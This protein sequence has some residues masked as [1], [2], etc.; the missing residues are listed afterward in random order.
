MT[1]TLLSIVASYGVWVVLCSA[2]IS[3]LAVPIPT[4][5][6]MLSAGAF[7]AAGDL[8]IYA[9]FAAS[10]IGAILGDQ[11]GFALGR[12]GGTRI[13]NRLAQSKGRRALLDRAQNFVQRWGGI[14]VF[15]STWLFAPLG[16]WVN[17]V[18]GANRLSWLRFSIADFAGEVIW[19]SVYIGLGFTFAD[20]IT[21]I[22]SLLSSSVAFLMGGGLTILLGWLLV[23]AIKKQRIQT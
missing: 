6:V 19:V 7:A 15:L 2:Y 5:L 21:Q 3:C 13:L 14:G 9:V 12:F 8:D 1:E 10:L 11:T 17:F 20:R 22:A 18:A 4:A 23:R 16:P